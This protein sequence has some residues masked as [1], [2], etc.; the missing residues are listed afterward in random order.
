MEPEDHHFE[1]R[2]N[3]KAHS[4]VTEDCHLSDIATA[5]KKQLMYLVQW[6]L[7]ILPEG[8]AQWMEDSLVEWSYNST[9]TEALHCLASHVVTLGVGAAQSPRQFVHYKKLLGAARVFL[10][11]V[12]IDS[13][14]IFALLLPGE[15]TKP[16][17]KSFVIELLFRCTP[18]I[19][20]GEFAYHT[21]STPAMTLLL[22]AYLL[23]RLMS[24]DCRMRIRE[25]KYCNP[26]I[27]YG[28]GSAILR[29]LNNLD[30]FPPTLPDWWTTQLSSIVMESRIVDN[31]QQ[32][33]P[34]ETNDITANSPS[35]EEK[36]HQILT[37]RVLQAYVLTLMYHGMQLSRVG[38][39]RLQHNDSR[40]ESRAEMEASIVVSFRDKFLADATQWEFRVSLMKESNPTEAFQL[41]WYTVE[42]NPFRSYLKAYWSLLGP[43]MSTHDLQ[44]IPESFLQALKLKPY[45]KPQAAF[46]SLLVTKSD[47]LRPTTIHTTLYPVFLP[48]TNPTNTS[49]ST[50]IT[51]ALTT[52]G[53]SN[54]TGNN[55][56]AN[57]TDISTTPITRALTTVGA[58]TTTGSNT[59]ASATDIIISQQQPRSDNNSNTNTKSDS[60]TSKQQP[61]RVVTSQQQPRSNNNNN[62]NPN[63]DSVKGN[64]R[65]RNS[66]PSPRGYTPTRKLE[67]QQERRSRSKSPSTRT[68][69]A[70]E[71]QERRASRQS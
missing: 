36:G 12:F 35:L 2:L 5:P 55:T 16:G 39:S 4:F 8:P 6:G 28:D 42:I 50:P 45:P 21:W 63:T 43:L 69:S 61:P 14:H 70:R 58:S 65:P 38:T 15:F 3:I 27:N 33:Y 26:S 10:H 11:T 59:S 34:V 62:T 48:S 19:K 68:N 9:R 23:D 44:P 13:V 25:D 71:S 54:T 67:T 17:V 20:T 22:T 29:I 56:S 60:V 47:D 37:I 24:P 18:F 64:Q 49:Q 1:H 51:R 53:V 57:S 7:D 41:F 52:V 31:L 46:D 30:T 32:H 66:S 40:T